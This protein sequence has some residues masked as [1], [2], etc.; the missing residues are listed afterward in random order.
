VQFTTAE[1]DA[2]RRDFTI[3]GLFLDPLDGRVIDY[4]DGQTDLSARRLRAIGDASQRFN[5]DYLRLLRAVRF[6]S[7]FDLSIEPHTAEQIRL[8]APRLR[9]ISPERVAEELRQMLTP[10][11]SRGRAWTLLWEFALVDEILRFLPGVAEAVDFNAQRSPFLHLAPGQPVP[12]GLAL[13][14]GVL[15]FRAQATQFTDPR[16]FLSRAH[17]QTANHALRQSLRLSN[18]ESDLFQGTLQGVAMLSADDAPTLA[19]KKRFL[20]TPTWQESLQLMESL[21]TTGLLDDRVRRLRP[22]LSDLLNQDFAPAPLVTGDDLTTLG[23]KPGPI[24]RR[25]LETLYDEQL[26]GNLTSRE[27]ALTRADSLGQSGGR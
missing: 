14:A 11:L 17:V 19:I 24:F 8:H 23:L 13:A 10:A 12:F 18:D 16:Q 2:Q 22:E 25:I 20:A 27:Q 9:R 26:E 3:N 1:Y 21:H 7:R 15:C 4:V 5:E 6:A